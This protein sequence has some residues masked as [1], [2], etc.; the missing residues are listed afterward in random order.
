MSDSSALLPL[1]RPVYPERAEAL[2]DNWLDEIGE[3]YSGALTR[4][5]RTFRARQSGIVGMVR[6]HEKHFGPL[7]PDAIREQARDLGKALRRDG[8]T[9][10]LVARSFALI[11][12]AAER[13]LGMRPFDVQLHGGWVLLRGMIAEMETGEGKTLTATL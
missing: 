8:F 12:I 6:K 2:P 5:L 1:V 13:V 11:C 4:T 3:R 9:H 7:Q 10:D